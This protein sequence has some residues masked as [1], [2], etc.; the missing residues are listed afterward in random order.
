MLQLYV[1]ETAF[2]LTSHFVVKYGNEIKHLDFNY[3]A[4]SRKNREHLIYSI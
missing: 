4:R 2:S 3:V 1:V